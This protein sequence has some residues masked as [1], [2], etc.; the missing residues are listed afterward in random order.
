[1]ANYLYSP[2]ACKATPGCR[3]CL[4]GAGQSPLCTGRQITP[5]VAWLSACRDRPARLHFL[6]SGWQTTEQGAWASEL[7]CDRKRRILV[8]SRNS[9][10]AAS[11]LDGGRGCTPP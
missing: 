10:D 9:A 8:L 7:V 3:A 2:T 11:P 5:T 1:M 4:L 6:A